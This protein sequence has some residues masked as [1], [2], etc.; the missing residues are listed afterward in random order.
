MKLKNIAYIRAF[1]SA[2]FCQEYKS[3]EYASELN[4][5]LINQYIIP[6]GKQPEETFTIPNY[7]V[8][9][10]LMKNFDI[11]LDCGLEEFEEQFKGN[12]GNLSIV[13]K[14]LEITNPTKSKNPLVMKSTE[15]IALQRKINKTYQSNKL[16]K[17]TNW[18]KEEIEET[19]GGASQR[20]ILRYIIGIII[21]NELTR[22]DEEENEVEEAT[23]GDLIGDTIQEGQAKRI[24]TKKFDL[25]YLNRFILEDEFIKEQPSQWVLYLHTLVNRNYYHINKLSHLLNFEEFIKIILHF[26]LVITSFSQT[27]SFYDTSPLID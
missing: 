15:N 5:I 9:F 13:E 2:E 10:Y 23:G 7:I 17:K 24:K 18:L 26:G 25:D 3:F 27:Y 12:K 16:N 1:L 19:R 8:I 4:K 11:S 14:Y 21:L 6:P 22:V 20:G